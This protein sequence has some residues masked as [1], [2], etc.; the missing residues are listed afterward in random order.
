M[1]FADRLCKELLPS[2]CGLPA[3]EL[4][5]TIVRTD[6]TVSFWQRFV[7]SN[8]NSVRAEQVL[9][10]IEQMEAQQ[11]TPPDWSSLD[12]WTY[13]MARQVEHQARAA[14]TAPRQAAPPST[15]A[16]STPSLAT[17]STSTTATATDG[18][19]RCARPV[20]FDK[21]PRPAMAVEQQPRAA[22]ATTSTATTATPTSWAAAAA[23]PSRV[24]WL[25]KPALTVAISGCDV[26]R[27][28]SAK[29]LRV[30]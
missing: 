8:F 20:H 9:E 13:I 4:R 5:E 14:S 11:R 26:C 24:P 15:P 12:V 17:T 7:V 16:S 6:D 18:Q 22:P 10:V 30:Y 3:A 27:C 23:P 25:H 1:T 29:L 19:L 28:E 21:S 2:C